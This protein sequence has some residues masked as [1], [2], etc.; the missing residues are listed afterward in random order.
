[1]TNTPKPINN[2]TL[3]HFGEWFLS[4]A[5]GLNATLCARGAFCGGVKIITHRCK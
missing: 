3:R 1:M 4:S 5:E 2:N